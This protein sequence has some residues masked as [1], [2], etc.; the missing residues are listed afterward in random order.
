[1][2]LLQLSAAQAQKLKWLKTENDT[3]YITDLTQRLTVR[4]F[5]ANKSA[6]YA[7][8]DYNV[9]KKILY[10]ANDNYNLGIGFNYKYIGL[11]MGFKLPLVNEDTARYGKTR[12]FDVQ[13]FIYLRKITLD[14]Y[15]LSYNG[16]YLSSRS[17]LKTTPATNIFPVRPDLRTR[18]IG[19]NAQYI[20]NSKR[21]SFRAPF[22]QNEYQKKSAGSFM[23][24]A[25]LHGIRVRA[26]SAIIPADTRFNPYFGN[27][28]FTSS[29]I[30][31]LS[32]NA[33]YAHTFVIKQNYFITAALLGGAGVNY[34]T[35]K[36]GM[37]KET[38][39]RLTHQFNSIVRLATGY[40]SVNYF[41]GMQ[42]INFINRNN[43][44]IEGAW[45]EFQ[46]GNIRLT[47]VQRFKL[48]RTV[49]KKIDKIEKTIK[50]EIGIEGN[51]KK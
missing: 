37:N 21:F 33:G 44:P 38:D 11:N 28:T 42:Y 19:M 49:R 10:R 29:N 20:F 41:V 36:G 46:S 4:I 6:K 31:T 32:L 48:D 18:N 14:I 9:G 50:T 35:I 13:S 34:T 17:M 12:F 1:M 23:A 15:L 22:L 24:G 2:L 16:Y 27:S 26:D 43:T 7:L 45:Q 5:V 51:T 30:I 40:S 47:F 3:S 25:G 39:G 8:G